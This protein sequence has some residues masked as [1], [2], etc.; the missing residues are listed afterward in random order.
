[1]RTGRTDGDESGQ[2]AVF[3]AQP[4]GNPRTHRGSNEVRRA[5]VHAQGRFAVS[6]PFGMQAANDAEV[7]GT[8]GQLRQKLRYPEPGSAP[9]SEFP[10]RTQQR[11][12]VFLF[13]FFVIT[14]RRRQLERTRLSAFAVETRLVIERVCLAR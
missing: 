4:V 11:W 2:A 8:A 10:R 7:I 12:N 14:E 1:M 9:L 5:G 6:L 3:R 13:V